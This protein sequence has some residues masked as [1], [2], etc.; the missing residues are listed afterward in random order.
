MSV[1]KTVI[2][3]PSAQLKDMRDLAKKENLTL[4]ELIRNA[5]QGYRYRRAL[6]ELN[7]SGRAKAAELGI[8][9]AD[10]VPLIH[11]F[12]QERRKKNKQPSE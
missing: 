2:S 9:E 11:Q 3:V 4:S 5:Y 6:K 7:E 12:R 1:T 10:V 8:A